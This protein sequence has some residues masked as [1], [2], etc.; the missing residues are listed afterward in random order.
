MTNYAW[1][2]ALSDEERQVIERGKYGQTRGLGTSPVL[3][4]IDCQ[5]NYLGEDAPIVEQQARW[6]AG[7]GELA[8]A[9]VRVIRTVLDTARVSEIPVV[10]TRNVQKRTVTFDM[11]SAKAGWDHRRTLDGDPGT[12]IVPDLAPTADDIVID[13]SYASAFWGTPLLTYLVQ[14]GADSVIVG[15]VSTSGCVRATSVDAVTRGFSTAVLT[16]GVAD[17]IQLSH[18]ASL[19]DLW[20]KYTDLMSGA[21]AVA[22]LSSVGDDRA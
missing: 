1:D 8:W 15:G 21:E 4:I 18:K 2:E 10:Y 6:P 13:K 12:Q 11:V 20:M 3:L 7:G 14:L 16:D 19:L 17:R 5:P 22:Y 9:A